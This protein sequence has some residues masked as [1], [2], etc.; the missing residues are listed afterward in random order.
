MIQVGIFYHTDPLANV[1]SGIDSIIQG[2]MKFAPPD[3][4][5]T[6]FGAT[7]DPVT[8][9]VGVETSFR[10]RARSF[11]F[12]P[13]IPLA[14]GHRR[15]LVP[16]TVRYLGALRRAIRTGLCRNLDVLDFHRIEPLLLFR[17]D[18]R[19]KNLIIHQDMRVIRGEHSDILWRYAPALYDKLETEAMRKA[20]RVFCVRQSAVERY[21]QQNPEQTEKF[22]FLPTWV[23]DQIFSTLDLAL[24][25]SANAPRPDVNLETN[26]RTYRLL[27]VGRLDRQ[28]NPLLLIDA[29][30]DLVTNGCDVHLTI[31]GDGDLRDQLAARLI[32]SRLEGRVE[33]L[34]VRSRPEIAALMR[35][36]D[37]FVLSSAYEG[38]PVVVLESLASGLPVVSTEVGEVGLVV[39]NGVN[40]CLVRE[41]TSTALAA[42]VADALKRLESLK[43]VPCIRSVEPYRAERALEAIYRNHHHQGARRDPALMN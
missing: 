31:I 6:L 18:P 4:D 12:V 7:A 19:P 33:L 17:R 23:D 40:G 10:L 39:R 43:G 36:A 14:N 24:S 38:M 3:I 25:A 13:L 20:S 26:G 9:P 42:G 16:N 2:M 27:F 1:A 34:G 22:E 35:S 41:H 37:L 8:R 21:R 11:R 32:S 15:P 30:R 5:Y 28:K 29:V